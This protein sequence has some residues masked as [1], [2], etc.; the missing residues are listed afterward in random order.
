MAAAPLA[1]FE[2][3]VI[4][5]PEAWPNS[6][7]PAVRK[8]NPHKHDRF[9][10]P[11]WMQTR[12]RDPDYGHYTSGPRPKPYLIALTRSNYLI[13][14]FQPQSRISETFAKVFSHLNLVKL[15]HERLANCLM[16]GCRGRPLDGP[17]RRNAAV[18]LLSCLFL[19]RRAPGPF[20]GSVPRA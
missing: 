9:I 11:P 3:L 4:C 1:L 10:A 17:H 18:S 20:P 15:R 14:C 5:G 12:I 2:M 7:D 19:L 8:S 16:A 6:L 13:I